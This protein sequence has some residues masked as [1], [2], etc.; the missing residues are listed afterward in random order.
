MDPCWARS[1]LFWREDIHNALRAIDQANASLAA[2]LPLEA[3]AIYRAGFSAALRAVA[4]CFDIH[5][6]LAPPPALDLR[7]PFTPG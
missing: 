7:D 6:D 1:E 3:V 4:T 2:H 5:L